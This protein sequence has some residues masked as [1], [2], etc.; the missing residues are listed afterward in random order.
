M[1]G[2]NLIKT[3]LKNHIWSKF[4]DFHL[5]KEQVQ[6]FP[7]YHWET[8]ITQLQLTCFALSP[9]F[10][11]SNINPSLVNSVFLQFFSC[12]SFIPI[13]P[14]F[15]SSFNWPNSSL[16]FFSL[17]AWGSL[18]CHFSVKKLIRFCCSFSFLIF[19]RKLFP[20]VNIIQFQSFD[21]LC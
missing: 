5:P 21:A 19:C 4:S 13:L 15:F 8:F 11:I 20:S 16:P 3:A 2:L 17:K 18:R 7:T 6:N 10:N 9:I 12:T 1:F 14:H